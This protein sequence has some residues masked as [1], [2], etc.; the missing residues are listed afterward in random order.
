MLQIEMQEV[1]G[2]LEF[3]KLINRTMKQ[4]KIIGLS[5]L[6]VFL[7]SCNVNKKTIV[8]IQ[9]IPDSKYNQ[10]IVDAKRDILYGAFP[11]AIEKYEEIIKSDSNHATAHYE[12][13]KIYLKNQEYEKATFHSKRAFDSNSS[14]IWYAHIYAQSLDLKGDIEGSSKMYEYMLENWNNDVELWYEYFRFLDRY[15]KYTLLNKYLDLF[16]KKFGF[17]DEIIINRYQSFVKKGKYKNIEK[18]LLNVLSADIKNEF[19]NLIL[20]DFYSSTRKIDKALEIYDRLLSYNSNNEQALLGKIKIFLQRNDIQSVMTI[21]SKIIEN[22]RIELNLKLG[23]ISELS[24]AFEKVK[25]FNIKKFDEFIVSLY[26]QYPENPDIIQFYGNTEYR[27]GNSKL[28]ISLFLKSLN[29]KPSNL[30]TWLF[31]LYILEREKEFNRIVSVADSALIYF[32]NQK[33]LFLLRGFG[34]LQTEE[35]QK[36]YD[37]FIFALKITGKLDKDRIQI[38]HYL[39]EVTYKMKRKEEAFKFYDEILENDQNDIVA[40]NNY[41]YYL[42]IEGLHLEKALEMS[43]KTIKK[44]PKNST[45]LDTY[46]YILFRLERYSDALKYIELAILN[47][48]TN[49]GV[50][51]EHY[52]DILFKNGKIDLAVSTW[53]EA[54]ERG[55]N[56]KILD[57]KIE[58]KEFIHE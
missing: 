16:E 49:S 34:Y 42:S 37:D 19:A 39:A 58:R 11:I 31:T 15:E 7:I 45:Y 26:K 12:L 8:T 51:L 4:Y 9:H 43:G 57:L 25:G 38:L 41:A 44:E 3:R 36:S 29:I 10:K 48:G 32:P 54:K 27:N 1:L 20:A 6:L 30:Q 53:K 24:Q 46:A 50:I 23:I 17:S 13:A 52:G 55:E 35:L 5:S 40:L 22:T 47:G 28:A 14:N 2:I 21:A 56:S 33:D 18:Y